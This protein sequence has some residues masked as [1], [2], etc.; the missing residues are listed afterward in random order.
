MFANQLRDDILYVT[1]T[2]PPPQ[3]VSSLPKFV[4]NHFA[5]VYPIQGA[6]GHD[7]ARLHHSADGTPGRAA[8]NQ[9]QLLYEV[10]LHK[11]A[12]TE[13]HS[14]TLLCML[15]AAQCASPRANAYS[16]WTAAAQAF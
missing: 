11:D 10:M 1:L 3:C 9:E 14:Q 15:L 2:K 16:K 13:A 4:V 12:C 7:V 6:W 8:Q 5:G